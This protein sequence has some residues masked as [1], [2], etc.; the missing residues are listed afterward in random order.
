[1]TA[2]WEPLYDDLLAD[3]LLVREPGEAEATVRFLVERL[4]L[5]PGARVFD[6]CCGIGGLSLPLAARGFRV[7]GV[8]QS[9]AYIERGL[10]EAREAG[11]QVELHAAD[12]LEFVPA[13]PADGA[14][15]WWTSFG[16][17]P[18][19]EGNL[20]MLRRAFDA[21]R[22]GGVFLLDSLHLPGVL[23]GF[24]R[25]VVLRR[26]TPR[27][28]VTLLRESAIDLDRGT[29]EKLWTYF[30]PDGS[31]VSHPSSLR[32]YMPHQVKAM[33]EAAGFERVTLLGSLR[34]EPLGLDSP[35]L[36]CSARRPR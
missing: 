32:L 9:A 21:L 35:R 11:L 17:P 7:V 2:W 15:N 33:L 31:R 4:G 27:G 12:A 16:H 6:Q 26:A 18:T 29:M 34:G 20:R 36:I 10:R 5:T 23:R 28:E 30:L 8:D 3:V 13:E 25:D 22:P 24:Q 14:F 19:D 1:M